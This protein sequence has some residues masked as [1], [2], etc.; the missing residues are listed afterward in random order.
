[1]C[2]S[3]LHPDSSEAGSQTPSCEV[4]TTGTYTHMLII[5]QLIPISVQAIGL[6]G[7]FIPPFLCWITNT[8]FVGSTHTLARVARF[9]FLLPGLDLD[10]VHGTLQTVRTPESYL[11]TSRVAGLGSASILPHFW[12]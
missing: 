12:Q 10:I 9:S 11:S 7:S 3:P 5:H 2:S 6:G 4:P 1:M 8:L